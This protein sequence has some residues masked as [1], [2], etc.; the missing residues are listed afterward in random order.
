[1]PEL[2]DIEIILT[3]FA[4]CMS[5]FEETR[6]S[7]RHLYW[8]NSHTGKYVWKKETLIDKT[9]PQVLDKMVEEFPDQLAIKFT[10]LDYTRTY[11]QFRDD[12]DEFARALIA[13]GVRAGSKVTIW[14]TNVPQWFLTF[15]AA[16]KIGAIL[17]TMNTAYKIHEAEYLLRHR[18]HTT[19]LRT[20]T[21]LLYGSF[22]F[23]CH[24]YLK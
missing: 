18:T 1:M 6:R 3:H 7:R 24:S 22:F 14:A 19:I 4:S 2:T 21:S 12:V 8:N 20:R 15:W 5:R 17:V 10:T 13:M 16:T 11:S 23:L 9:F